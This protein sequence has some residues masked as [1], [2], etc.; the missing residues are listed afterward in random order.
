MAATPS[1]A[2]RTAIELAIENR[3]SNNDLVLRDAGLEQIP[4][5]NAFNP[6]QARGATTALN[7]AKTG[8]G[9]D[10]FA[11]GEMSYAVSGEIYVFGS[12]IANLPPAYFQIVRACG[13]KEIRL[14]SIAGGS[15]SLT[16]TSGGSDGHL[17]A[18]DG[19]ST[20]GYS[21]KYTLLYK[22]DGTTPATTLAEAAF[23]S[24]LSTTTGTDATVATDAHIVVAVLPS[25]GIKRVYRT[26]AN[27][28]GST[29]PRDYRYV[30]SVASGVTTMTDYL[31]DYNLGQTA[32]LPGVEAVGSFAA[33]TSPG[34]S[35][36]LTTA[37]R[38]RFSVLYDRYGHPIKVGTIYDADGSTVLATLSDETADQAADRA[39]YEA[40]LPISAAVTGTTATTDQ[41][42]VL[43]FTGVTAGVRRVYRQEGGV[44]ASAPYYFVANVADTATTNALD[45]GLD[46]ATLV[47]HHQMYDTQVSGTSR[48]DKAIYLPVSEYL[49]FDAMTFK[50][51]LDSRRYPVKSARGTM[52]FEGTVGGNFLGRFTLEGIYGSSTKVA[53]PTLASNPGAP[54]QICNIEL[55]VTPESAPTTD[56]TLRV[57]RFGISFGRQPAP[58][59]DAN[60][61]CD[62][63]GLLEYMISNPA[64]PRLTATF[65]VPKEIG[66]SDDTDWI[67][68]FKASEFYAFRFHIGN[69]AREKVYF[70]NWSP[71]M[72]RRF[73]AQL[74]EPPQFESDGENGIRN[75]SGNWAL[76]ERTGIDASMFVLRHEV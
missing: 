74:A 45:D 54:P 71:W 70:T 36:D 1:F 75:F 7:R 20:P 14:A 6:V 18:N 35:L 56:R 4:I 67:N 43:N 32:P 25:T 15:S 5:Y 8:L 19:G 49:D 38:Y 62:N 46:D 37:Y 57:S 2:A 63:T 34:G 21:Y 3:D 48:P 64:D 17:T 50:C 52:D 61:P 60:A 26:K 16:A 31:A 40:I 68:D 39:A 29:D 65:E 10:G 47:T 59:R 41:S 73:L 24:R 72:E 30:G 76:T 69:D 11:I 51:Y 55:Q 44:G 13:F 53:N 12:G 27:H 28:A 66:T 58:R 23:E 9:S 22:A 33:A 42:L